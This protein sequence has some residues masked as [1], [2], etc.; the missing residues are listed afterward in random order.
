M[1]GIALGNDGCCEK[2]VKNVNS[3][4]FKA[5]KFRICYPP[6]KLMNEWIHFSRKI[7]FKRVCKSM[8]LQGWI[9]PG[10]V[11]RWAGV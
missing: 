8:I 6:K 11:V 10:R 9:S 5:I 2:V 4:C 1:A 7:Q 3:T